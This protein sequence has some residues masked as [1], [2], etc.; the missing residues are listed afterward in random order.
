[1]SDT[2]LASGATCFLGVVFAPSTAGSSL[3]GSL[4]I[5]DDGAGSPH[6]VSLHGSSVQGPG[7]TSAA[8][9]TFTVGSS[10]T[11][12]VTT[13]GSPSPSLSEVGALPTGITFADNGDGTGTLSGTPAATTG[14]TYS[15]TFSAHNTTAPDASQV[16]TLTVNQAAAI[17]SVNNATFQNGSAGSFTVTSSGFPVPSLAQSGTLPAGITFTDNHDGT[18]KLSGTPTIGGTFVLTL[19]ASN[20]VGT[21]ASQSFTLNVGQGPLFTSSTSTSFRIATPG[22]FN[23]TTTGSPAPTISE[24]GDLPSGV[25]FIDN[26]NGTA[27]FSGTPAANSS[28]IYSV[29]LT[30][31]NSTLPNALQTFTL[32]VTQPPA[33]TSASSA[34]FTIGTAGSFTISTSGFPKAVIT[35]SGALPGGVSFTDNHDGTAKLAGTPAAGGVFNLALTANNGVTPNA[36]QSFT[37]TVPQSPAITSAAATAFKV[38][39][40]GSFTVATTGSPAATVSETGAL[41]AGVTFVPNSN[42]TAKLSGTPAAGSA[43]TYNLATQPRTV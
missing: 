1:M 33:F 21:D 24:S 42:G 12:T 8:N 13:S 6:V 14:G 39:S 29:I 32:I 15:L 31:Q 20:G 7:I 28:G 22:S 37:L 11:F 41:P 17:T 10:G 43:G 23:I 3:N 40:A 9:A 27:K 5:T 4:T 18:G 25:T 30:A 19:T 2:P 35:E 26:G 36:T 34:S 16:F 38:G